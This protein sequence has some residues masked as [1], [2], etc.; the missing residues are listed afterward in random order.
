[1]LTETI[2]RPQRASASAAARRNGQECSSQNRS[3]HV[4]SIDHAFY[5]IL[6]KS[7]KNGRASLLKKTIISKG[8]GAHGNHRQTTESKCQC[9]CKVRWAR[10]LEPKS[11]ASCGQ[12]RSCLLFDSKYDVHTK[13]AAP[14]GQKKQE[15]SIFFFWGSCAIPAPHVTGSRAAV[16]GKHAFRELAG[17]GLPRLM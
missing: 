17:H 11:L 5:S 10:I 13:T 1:M 2:G 14:E 4:T 9:C 16:Y 6:R 3:P 15:I 8:G 12:H 7:Y